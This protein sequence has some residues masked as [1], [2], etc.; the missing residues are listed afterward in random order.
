[1]DTRDVFDALGVDRIFSK[2]LLGKL[3]EIE[4]GMWLEWRGPQGDQQPHK[5]TAREM[6]Q[7]YRDFKIKPRTV[8]QLGTRQG[9]GPSA[10]GYFLKDFEP[11]WASYCTPR[12]AN[13]PTHQRTVRLIGNGTR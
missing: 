7:M 8:S 2:D 12:A 4:G 10:M 5:L 11:A 13:A 9:R 3:H 1:M 6:A